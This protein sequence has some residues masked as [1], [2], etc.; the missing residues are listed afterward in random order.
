ML[1]GIIVA[2]AVCVY[3]GLPVLPVLIFGA[4]AMCWMA[5]FF[6][7]NK[8]ILNAGMAF[9]MIA[10]TYL[11]MEKMPKASVLPDFINAF[12]RS[13]EVVGFFA[14]V[15]IIYSAI[16]GILGPLR[17]LPTDPADVLK[18]VRDVE[19]SKRNKSE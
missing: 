18:M 19:K 10:F 3:F 5:Y 9:G 6:T 17:H 8:T 14:V 2:M 11:I 1:L 12:M 15:V 13:P 7:K 4:F 16:V